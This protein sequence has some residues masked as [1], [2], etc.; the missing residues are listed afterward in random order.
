MR[1]FKYLFIAIL[2]VACSKDGNFFVS[3]EGLDVPEYSARY[4]KLDDNGNGLSSEAITC[5]LELKSFTFC[6]KPTQICK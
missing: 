6:K 4:I 3:S 2:C 5:K 1:Y